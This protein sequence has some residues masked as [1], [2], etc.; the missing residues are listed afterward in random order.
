VRELRITGGEPL[1]RADL[2]DIIAALRARHPQLPISMTTNGVGLEKKAQ[3]LKE[4]GLTR[5]NVP[6]TP[7]T[8]KFLPN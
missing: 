4:A 2:V 3:A 6:W 7:C 5:V 1:V 8:R